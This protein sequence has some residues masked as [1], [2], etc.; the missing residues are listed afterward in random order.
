M[1]P[2]V[3]SKERVAD[4]GEVYTAPREV[5]VNTLN[6]LTTETNGGT[7]TVAGTT[8]MPVT[9]VTANGSTAIRYA[10]STFALGGFSLVNGTNTFTA[11]GQDS[12]G[13]VSTNI[14]NCYLPITNSYSYDLNGNLLGDGTR[15]FAYDDENQL[16]G[17]WVANVWSNSFVYDGLLRKRI[18][19]DYGWNGSTWIETNEVRCLYD[20]Y[21]VIQER[22][23]NNLP[24][25]TYTR[26]VDLGGNESPLLGQMVDGY[27]SAGGIGGLLARTDMGAW[28][29][30]N[31]QATA[32][33]FNDAQGNVIA[34]INTNG[35]LVAQYEY[36]PFGNI[37][38]M[39]GPLASANR[40]RFSSKE[41]NDNA[42]LYY[43][44]LRFYDP[45]LQRWLNRDPIQE[46]GGFNLFT[47]ISNVAVNSVDAFGLCDQVPNLLG[48]LPPPSYN[49]PS[50][51]TSPLN[52]PSL[53][54]YASSSSQ[55]KNALTTVGNG[56]LNDT[57]LRNTLSQWGQNA[58][59]SI[60][61]GLGDL[62]GGSGGS[63]VSNP[64]SINTGDMYPEAAQLA[65]QYVN[66]Y[67]NDWRGWRVL[68]GTYILMK[69]YNESIFA[70]KNAVRL[71]DKESCQP[72][73]A[74]AIKADKINI[75]NEIVPEL[76]DLK[77]AKATP[78]KDK[79]NCISILLLY[80][81][82][83]DR[84]DIFIKTLAGENIKQ[85]LQNDDVK[86]DLISGCKY[87]EGKDI[88]KIRQ[89]LEAVMEENSNSSNT[90]SPSP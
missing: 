31:S 72:L 61:P 90:N 65:R 21:V 62:L 12:Y 17:V 2:Q 19:K 24:R 25:V 43:Y 49:Q 45:N 46:D 69:S 88:E 33:Y 57:G 14:S 67:S 1:H 29:G 78:E 71:G 86:L 81:V 44:G 20:G 35:A 73:A 77:D 89:S 10:D 51:Q 5:N 66:V 59:N 27:Q 87:F 84:K 18:E 23:Q 54:P 55:L 28:I 85:I 39:S 7:L 63:G 13:H 64:L 8:T 34:M 74:A 9:S 80:S 22:D 6:E 36:D 60:Y 48:P 41:W 30:N 37:L 16:T 38:S 11:I 52:L 53:N 42:G 58:L 68:G 79:L 26:G 32:Y 70:Y 15:N 76:M 47:F 40:Y 83:S 56:L 50:Q 3:I 75:I 4:H 82:K